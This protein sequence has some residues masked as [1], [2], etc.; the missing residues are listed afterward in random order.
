MIGAVPATWTCCPSTHRARVPDVAAAATPAGTTLRLHGPSIAAVEALRLDRRR[1]TRRTAA[2]GVVRA[3]AELGVT[4]RATPSCA[5]RRSRSSLTGLAVLVAVEEGTVDLDEPAG[6]PGSTLRHLLRTRRG[7][8]S[9]RAPPLMPPGAAADLLE[10]RHRG[11]GRARRRARRDAVRRLL[12]RR[13]SSSRSA[14]RRAHGSPACGLPRPARRPARARARAARA[15]ARRAGDARRG[16]DACSSRPRGRAARLRA[17]GPERLGSRLRA[18]RRQV[19]AL[20]RART[21]RRGRSATSAQRARS[22]GSTRSWARVRRASPIT[23]SASGRVK[24][25]RAS[26]TQC[27]RRR[28]TTSLVVANSGRRNSSNVAWSQLA[29]VAGVIARTD[30]VRGMPIA[31]ATSPK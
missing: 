29:T 13:R 24:P 30:A 19:A 18:P 2:A 21:T 17:D 3:D 20:D 12:P 26:A 31:S 10:R 4:A 22:S 15:D 11:R 16:D 23:S 14:C 28:A 27:S 7:C 9:T 6:P 1:G 8:R 5:G 25:G